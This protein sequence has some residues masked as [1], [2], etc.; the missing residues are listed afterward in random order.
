[1]PAP[2]LILPDCH[3]VITRRCALRQF[4]LRPGPTTNAHFDYLLAEAARRTGVRIV[5]YL[6]MSNHYHAIVRDT[7]G[8]LPEFL[9]YFHKMLA[10][11]MNCV[12]GRWE[13]FWSSEP[14]CVTRLVT[15]E[16]VLEKLLYVLG[17]PV[18]DHLVDRVHQW[19]GA[20]SLRAMLSGEPIHT[21]RPQEFF[22]KNGPMPE[23]STLHLVRP[24]GFEDYSQEE[25]ANYLRGRLSELELEA[26][27]AR[28]AEGKGVLGKNAVLA[29]SH[30]DAPATP[31]PRRNLRPAIACKDPALRVRAIRALQTFRV[32][33]AKARKLFVKGVRDV[34]FPEGT[35]HMRLMGLNCSG[36][37]LAC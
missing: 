10:R 4:G 11:S 8:R 9:E 26:R 14:P 27:K 20:H 21:K 6:A 24:P 2:R 18:N 25:W 28:L 37:P 19:P 34:V 36:P 13:N 16:D 35:Y 33:Y 12:W 31:A 3:Y 17:N 32:A 30:R 1:M 5:G 23:S 15:P 22:R 7:E 29:A